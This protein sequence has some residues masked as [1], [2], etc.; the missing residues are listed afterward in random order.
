MKKPVW[1]MRM[2]VS[3]AIFILAVTCSISA[4]S[5]REPRG[6]GSSTDAR[7]PSTASSFACKECPP[8][9]AVPA[10]PAGMRRISHVAAYELTWAQYL[11]AVDDGSCTFPLRTASGVA[12]ASEERRKFD[13]NWTASKLRL[14]D[15]AC[16]KS[17]IQRKLPAG[18]TV[19]IPNGQEWIWLAKA[20]SVAP[21]ISAQ[22]AVL[23]ESESFFGS[24]AEPESLRLPVTGEVSSL[25][26]GTVGRMPPNAWGLYDMIGQHQEITSWARP[27]GKGV[28]AKFQI[29]ELRGGSCLT[30]VTKVP[31]DTASNGMVFGDGDTIAPDYAVR[32]IIIRTS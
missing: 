26:C 6:E 25:Y 11:R 30:P 20:G 28:L 31:I 19:D 1:L 15:V 3:A 32:L 27:Q 21:K 14:S 18:Y 8:F 13:L 7:T 24:F 4:T 17:W 23:L 10:A 9:V 12:I 22:G 2:K 29:V 16:F 5:A